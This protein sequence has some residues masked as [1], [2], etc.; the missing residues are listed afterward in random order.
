MIE[1]GGSHDGRGLRIGVVAARFNELV[2]DRLLSGA[3]DSLRAAGV[4]SDDVVLVRVPGALEIPLA[5]QKLCEHG[6]VDAVVA[7][8]CVV[9]GE[10][11]HFDVV[12]RESA[13][14]IRRVALAT[15]VPVLNGILTTDTMD[16]ALD[17]AGGKSGN[18]GRDCAVGAVEM[19]RLA[20]SITTLASEPG[21]AEA[22]R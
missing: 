1:L 10:T 13:A 18:K 12:V 19:A 9:R 7:L 4:A 22:G 16:Q 5:A 8:G 20:A 21:W 6:A 17:R 2:T 11:A 15:G 3:L 14:G